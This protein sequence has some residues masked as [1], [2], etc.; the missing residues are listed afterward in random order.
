[1]PRHKIAKWMTIQEICKQRY[2]Q[3][4]EAEVEVEAT[5]LAWYYAEEEV[6]AFERESTAIEHAMEAAK[7]AVREIH[8]VAAKEGGGERGCRHGP[9]RDPPQGGHAGYGGH[10]ATKVT[11]REAA[12]RMYTPRLRMY[13]WRMPPW[14][15]PR[16]I[17]STATR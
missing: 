9:T 6:G 11:T 2:P 12:S 17:S 16:G 1:M 13:A 8:H 14:S 15:W 10:E 7:V 5:V 4:S 3:R